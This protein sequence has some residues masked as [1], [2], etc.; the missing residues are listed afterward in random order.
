[1]GL[2]LNVAVWQDRDNAKEKRAA[3]VVAAAA[4]APEMAIHPADC[5]IQPCDKGIAVLFNEDCVGYEKLAEALSRQLGRAVLVGSIY[6]GDFWGYYL[7][8]NGV[9]KDR[10]QTIPN[11]FE[12][13]DKKEL[14]KW[15]GKAR[16]LRKYFK[17][18]R[19]ISAYLHFWKED[20]EGKKVCP[21]DEFK[22][23]DCWQISD[24][25]HKLGFEMPSPKEPQS[26][27]EPAP[28]PVNSSDGQTGTTQGTR[29]VYSNPNAENMVESRKRKQREEDEAYT[30][31]PERLEPDAEKVDSVQAWRGSQ[32]QTF[33]KAALTSE[34]LAR[35]IEDTLAGEYTRLV[36]NFR[37]QG[38]GMYVKRLNKT[39]YNPIH[40]TLVLHHVDGKFACVFFAG[41]SKHCYALISDF[42]IYRTVEM[43]EI[44]QIPLGGAVLPE[45]V[46][47]QNRDLL[48]KALRYLFLDV[49]KIDDRLCSSQR[50]SAENLFLHGNNK[51]T[52]MRRKWGA[53]EE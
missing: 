53:L 22:M 44:R 49:E 35:L 8:D 30:R 27:T 33:D 10:F 18:S 9:E 32:I 39:V 16:L 52:E 38:E 2:F 31:L 45:Y 26:R 36:I 50:W 24:F 46:I 4:L 14:R 11:Y 20:I 21:D 17:C 43:D 51:Y 34:K 12:E 19:K 25:L 47:H 41:G 40:S 23:G 28:Q 42:H 7:Y 1:M 15:R 3:D 29:I 37:F 6:D 13:L 48:D 5:V